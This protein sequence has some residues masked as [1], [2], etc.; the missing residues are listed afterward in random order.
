MMGM[1]MEVTRMTTMM[2]MNEMKGDC[3]YANGDD[4]DDHVGNIN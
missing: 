1:L 2:T 4:D 3:D